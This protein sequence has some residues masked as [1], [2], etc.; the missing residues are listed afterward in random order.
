MK[1]LAATFFFT[2]VAGIAIF[3]VGPERL[4][5][6]I[7]AMAV[8]GSSDVDSNSES[9]E[10]AVTI[11]IGNSEG[12]VDDLAQIIDGMDIWVWLPFQ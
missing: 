10:P 12:Q 7:P 6:K 11:A 5:I 1:F 3:S 2:I 4:G 8:Q 9:A